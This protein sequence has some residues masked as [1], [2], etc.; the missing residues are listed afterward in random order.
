VT[1]EVERLIAAGES[2]AAYSYRNAFGEACEDE[3][4][5]LRAVRCQATWARETSIEDDAARREQAKKDEAE[6]AKKREKLVAA[7]AKQLA[8]DDAALRQREFIA[9]AA[10]EI[11]Q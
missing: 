11:P 4:L 5:G 3:R 10:Q 9:R 7:R 1:D 8:A 2:A 6:A